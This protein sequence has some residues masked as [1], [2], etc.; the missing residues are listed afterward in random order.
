[1]QLRDLRI[2]LCVHS[3]KE[4]AYGEGI[5]VDVDLIAFANRITDIRA[6]RGA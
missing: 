5:A 2:P 1:M 4:E 6:T 3:R